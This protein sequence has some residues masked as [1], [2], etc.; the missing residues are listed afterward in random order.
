M[1][2][3]PAKE[4]AA[5]SGEAHGGGSGKHATDNP[6]GEPWQVEELEKRLWQHAEAIV[7]EFCPATQ[8]DKDILTATQ[9]AHVVVVDIDKGVA[10]VDGTASSLRDALA[11]LCPQFRRH[12]DIVC[13]KVLRDLEGEDEGEL[14][15]VEDAESAPASPRSAAPSKQAMPEA[16]APTPTSMV[17]TSTDSVSG[18]EA[19]NGSGKRAALI[20]RG[21]Y[22]PTP[23]ADYAL[24]NERCGG[25]TASAKAVY[26]AMLQIA[27]D[28]STATFT[29]EIN[30][31]R[32]VAGV[33]LRTAK[34]MLDILEDLG[35]IHIKRRREPGTKENAPSTYTVWWCN[36]NTTY[37][38]SGSC[39]K[40]T[41][42]R[43]SNEAE[44][45]HGNNKNSAY[46]AVKNKRYGAERSARPHAPTPAPSGFQ[47]QPRNFYSP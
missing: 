4:N 7:V 2:G 23:K 5:P 21:G 34:S 37:K 12:F 22:F 6:T 42:G 32:S 44:N 45:L 25:K 36:N 40:R 14:E 31:I 47:K 26:A 10:M 27:N 28:R 30:V 15:D 1:D 3:P 20:R 41:T 24:L 43:A 39:N 9:G 17:N 38:K 13:D 8:R 29:V 11:C 19:G 35:L 46:S 18:N 33:S 16:A